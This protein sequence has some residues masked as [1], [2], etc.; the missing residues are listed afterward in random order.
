MTLDMCAFGKVSAAALAAFAGLVLLSGCNG[1]KFS[2]NFRKKETVRQ[3]VKVRVEAVGSASSATTKTYIG[4]VE[5]SKSAT[6]LSPFPAK[7]EKINVRQG[8]DVRANRQVAK[9]YS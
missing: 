7:L 5:A 4:R 3:P 1:G 6:V 8:Q 2:V 9:V